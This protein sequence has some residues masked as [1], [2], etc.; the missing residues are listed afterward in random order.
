MLFF[1]FHT[2]FLYLSC[3]SV[4]P[5]LGGGPPSILYSAVCPALGG[6][7]PSILC[8]LRLSCP[9]WWSAEYP[10]LPPSVMPSVVVRRV[11][12]ASSV[13]PA[14]GGGPPSIL[15]FLRLS[16]S[17]RWSAEYPVLPPSILPSAVVRRVS[18]ASKL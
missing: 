3:P 15:C 4:C 6:G 11:S 5:A 9:R 7:P 18:P 2:L 13:C 12:C 16:C 14:L 1:I 8:F 17:R 10:V